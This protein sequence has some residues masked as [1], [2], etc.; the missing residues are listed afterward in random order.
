MWSKVFPINLSELAS[1]FTLSAI[2]NG[3][4]NISLETFYNWNIAIKMS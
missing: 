3:N 1:F 4:E 2:Q